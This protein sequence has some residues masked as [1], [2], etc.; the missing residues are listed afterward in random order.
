MFL[1]ANLLVAIAQIL[2]YILWAY[3]WILLARVVISYINADPNNPLIRF[4]YGAT[5]PILSRVRA[6]LP[7]S[8]GGFDFS[9]V[10][11]WLAVMFLQRFL[12]RSLYDLAQAIS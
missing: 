12:V 5:E 11:V 8:S 1:V 7:L 2:D 4:L 9:P 10:I 6:K 3:A